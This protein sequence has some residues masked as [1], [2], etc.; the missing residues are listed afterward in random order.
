MVSFLVLTRDGGYVTVSEGEA[1][2]RVRGN[3]TIILATLMSFK[4]F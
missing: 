2:W 3:Y 4:L 1:R